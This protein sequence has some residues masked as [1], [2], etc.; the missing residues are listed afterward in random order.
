MV[1]SPSRTYIGGL[2]VHTPPVPNLAS[3][4]SAR[5]HNYLVDGSDPI[6]V[7]V[8]QTL[9]SI[10]PEAAVHLRVTRLTVGKYEVD[11]RRISV[12][13]MK[14][15]TLGVS[16]DEVAVTEKLPLMQYLRQAAAVAQH[17]ATAPKRQGIDS[18]TG[19]STAS[20][21]AQDAASERQSAMRLA[22][23][24]SFLI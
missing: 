2:T 9:R 4:R 20:V 11:G 17:T 10:E 13:W 19:R 21:L 24:K 18:Y 23:G 8:A 1:G 7:T 22:C 16:E 15:G 5:G 3:P 12:G 14:S 6:D